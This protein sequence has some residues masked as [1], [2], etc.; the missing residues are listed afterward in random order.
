MQK[1]KR[2]VAFYLALIM[3]FGVVAP[4][5]G[6]PV[7]VHANSPQVRIIHNQVLALGPGGVPVL[8]DRPGRS[9][10]QSVLLQWDLTTLTQFQVLRF[11]T[12]LGNRVELSLAPAVESFA[13]DQHLR[14]NFDIHTRYPAD[15]PP[16]TLL[17]YLNVRDPEHP[18][19]P[20][21]FWIY[22]A[23]GPVPPLPVP[24]NEFIIQP[25][26]IGAVTYHNSGIRIEAPLATAGTRRRLNLRPRYTD[27]YG[28]VNLPGGTVAGGVPVTQ[29]TDEYPN[30]DQ[31]GGILSPSGAANATEA[32][33]T[34]FATY[35]TPSFNVQ[36]GH[37][38]S[39]IY[40]NMRVHFLWTG[41]QFNVFFD[42]TLGPAFYQFGFAQ[43]YHFMLETFPVI[44]DFQ[45]NYFS[46]HWA[47][48]TEDL[49][50][51]NV[52]RPII[53]TRTDAFYYTGLGGESFR[54]N[55]NIY[56]F[57]I[58]ANIDELPRV[59]SPPTLPVPIPPARTGDRVVHALPGSTTPAI[60]HI[61]PL[62]HDI[63][64]L[65]I[66]IVEGDRDT[67]EPLDPDDFGF[68]LED[69]NDNYVRPAAHHVGLE[70]RFAIPTMFDE[71]LFDPSLRRFNVL[72]DEVGA[73]SVLNAQFF[74][75]PDRGGAGTFREQISILN[76][77]LLDTIDL[78]NPSVDHTLPNPPRV[79]SA[80][81]RDIAGRSYAYIQIFG[82]EPNLAYHFGRLVIL[83]PSAT[84]PI[85]FS[86]NS[87]TDFIP[88][89]AP[90]FLTFLEFDAFDPGLRD[91]ELQITPYTHTDGVYRIYAG[92]SQGTMT[93]ITGD[94]RPVGN[95]LPPIGIPTDTM[96]PQWYFQVVF[97]Q[98]GVE[99]RSQI[100]RYVHLERPPQVENANP[101]VIDQVEMRP[102]LNAD[103]TINTMMGDV[104][105]RATWNIADRNA[106]ERMFASA[107]SD[108]IAIRYMMHI[109]DIPFMDFPPD[110]EQYFPIL[111]EITRDSAVLAS[112]SPPA[113]AGSFAI[114]SSLHPEDHI[115]LDGWPDI[116]I[117][118]PGLDPDG[119]NVFPPGPGSVPLRVSIRVHTTAAH[120]TNP[121]ALQHRLLF[122]MLH[123]LSVGALGW[124]ELDGPGGSLENNTERNILDTAQRLWR[125]Q[126]VAL[127]LSEMV[128]DLPPPPTNLIVTTPAEG[129]TAG[130]SL[131]VQYTIPHIE[132]GNY[133]RNNPG[134][135][136]YITTSLY[137]TPFEHT[138]A[139]FITGAIDNNPQAEFNRRRG[140]ATHPIVIEFDPVRDGNTIDFMEIL[141]P[142]TAT[143]LR[144]ALRNPLTPMI[145]IDN[146][147][148]F[149][150]EF[151]PTT[152]G[153][154]PDEVDQG[155]FAATMSRLLAPVPLP[156]P[157]MV[158]YLDNLDENR[159]YF[160]FADLFATAYI[161]T[162]TP[163]ALYTKAR[164]LPAISPFSNLTGGTTRGYVELPDPG[165]IDPL[166]P[167]D[168]HYDPPP[169][170]T[171]VRLLW[172]EPSVI[173]PGVEIRYELLRIRDAEPLNAVQQTNTLLS[174]RETFDA[175]TGADGAW[176]VCP[177]EGVLIPDAQ[178]NFV[179]VPPPGSRFTY[180]PTPATILGHHGF[181]DNT[182]TPNTLYFYYVRTVQITTRAGLTIE[183]FSAWVERP[184]T[185]PPV[186]APFNFDRLDPRG[187]P[188]FDPLT[189]VYVAWDIHLMG[190]EGMN[191]QEAIQYLVEH[192]IGVRATFEFQLMRGDGPWELAP[193]LSLAQLRNPANISLN[194]DGSFTFRYVHSG[195]SPG[196]WHY[197]QVRLVELDENLQPYDRS[198]WSDP[199]GFL[200]E[201]DLDDIDLQDVADN[202]LNFL[203]YQLAHVLDRPYWLA[204]DTPSNAIIVYRGGQ[205]V[206]RGLVLETPGTNIPLRNTN[207]PHGAYNVTYYMPVEVVRF[208][209]DNNMGF[210]TSFSDVQFLMPSSFISFNH[211][212]TML[213][214]AR[215][216]NTTPDYTDMFVRLEFELRPF[217]DIEGQPPASRQAS[218]QVNAVTTNRNFSNI[219]AWDAHILRQAMNII[220]TRITDPILL[221][222]ILQRMRD[223]AT[224]E[225]MWL[226]IDELVTSIS[227]QI[228]ARVLSY[229]RTTEN[230]IL[231]NTTRNFTS[232]DVP[233]H[234]TLLVMDQ[235]MSVGAFMLHISGWIREQ[236]FQMANGPTI[237][238][239][240]PGTF[241]F[242]GR[243]IIIAD[244]QE[245]PRGGAVIAIVA[246][247]GLDDLFGDDINLHQNA[248]RHMIVGSAARI[249]GAPHG[250]DPIAW[251]AANLNVQMTNRN[252]ASLIQTQEAIAII[253]ALYERRTNTRVSQI[254]IRDTQAIAGMN[255]DPRYSQAVSAAFEL[256]IV[257]N[258][259]INP[260]GSITIGE[261]LD[262]LSQFNR[263]IS[264]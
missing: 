143:S 189:Q 262:M 23:I 20:A 99:T 5:A 209:F 16:N 228:S 145:R 50:P 70:V 239:R 91:R 83:G 234:V 247:F 264:L 122:P 132:L 27:W 19:I 45:N 221:Q 159:Q 67:F 1:F 96:P 17:G 111:V 85:F 169:S 263:R 217:A 225:E 202:W 53:G 109:Q 32:E 223:D 81:I 150:E 108:T 54:T 127:V 11:Y 26:E 152:G 94:I 7:V 237:S 229:L 182:L 186:D 48:Y 114:R 30:S 240:A 103:N 73:L 224:D 104:S 245:M 248:S 40:D 15:A 124:H 34:V 68:D 241:A 146:I 2:K 230:G 218:F 57:P 197:M 80:G 170:Q 201:F 89:A 258:R 206:F 10:D 101:L 162:T 195:L 144:D 227:A 95:N 60:Q 118:N 181:I 44:E 84:P 126:E 260:Q 52:P 214:M 175:I 141:V 174:L 165:D 76:I 200:T 161:T 92:P 244:I 253:M 18:S 88:F 208:A 151:Q 75:H 252:A 41:E 210:S 166:S 191:P 220:D 78:G 255:L 193:P 171:S 242:T 250:A 192:I 117:E 179:P 115:S 35:L 43:I 176:R 47:S 256:G 110:V 190:T 154:P 149:I 55:P 215:I 77:N 163:G 125:S 63:N 138:G 194:P 178:G 160:L 238:V 112:L 119:W 3:M 198:M 98:D 31:T 213:D 205:D 140:A 82:L 36:A 121:L 65:P 113:A 79:N 90:P 216:I 25:I 232:F 49:S 102:Q 233:V 120:Y 28:D 134:F 38:F 188:T 8:E 24:V 62:A 97:I 105:F 9:N 177:D 106:I 172:L 148:V 136:Q 42:G 173:L 137:I 4:F 56:L 139:D 86:G 207:S 58:A 203:R 249:A 135:A 184:V 236:H 71:A 61:D 13:I 183:R 123:Y 130:P 39:F 261:F 168:F 153:I 33:V 147:P 59:P 64:I 212:Q 116:R 243:V 37:G 259:N 164:L 235:D 158:L 22:D 129:V 231:T 72:P 12:S 100:I 29:V 254:I 133:V 6:P 66:E 251:S 222:S 131:R 69:R 204:Q 14:V 107:N 180:L 142:G 46:Q 226:L 155:S 219:A 196:T 246:T 156:L 51:G 21:P 167:R 128:D 257:T 74:L 157:Q 211:N 187:L 199:I 87:T 185:T 93:R